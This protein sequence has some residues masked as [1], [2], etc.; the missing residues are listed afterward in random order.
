MG[1]RKKP[2]NLENARNRYLRYFTVIVKLGNTKSGNQSLLLAAEVFFC[3]N[4]WYLSSHFFPLIPGNYCLSL[5]L[6]EEKTQLNYA[7]QNLILEYNTPGHS[8]YLMTCR[9]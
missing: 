5:Y 4:N 2:Q 3:E 8:I 6:I 1:N 7:G 9:V